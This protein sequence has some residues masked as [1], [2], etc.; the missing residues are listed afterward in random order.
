[1]PWEPSRSTAAASCLFIGN[2]A[3][4]SQQAFPLHWVYNHVPQ[5]KGMYRRRRWLAYAAVPIFL[6]MSL[7]ICNYIVGDFLAQFHERYAYE[8]GAFSVPTRKSI[9]NILNMALGA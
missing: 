2:L 9:T 6:F 3:L 7:P 4:L 8:A 5:Q 1:M